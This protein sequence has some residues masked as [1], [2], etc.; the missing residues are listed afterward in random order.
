MLIRLVKI[1]LVASLGLFLLTVVFNNVTDYKSNSDFV[2]HVLAMDTTFPSNAPM[3]RVIDRGPV[4][5]AF[6]ASIILWEA[7]ACGLLFA[8][9]RKI[10]GGRLADAAAFSR[11]KGLAVAGIAPNLLQW[12]VAF[13]AVAG[14][15]FLV[16]QS[17]SWNGRE[18]APRMYMIAGIL[19][20][21]LKTRDEELPA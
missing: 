3:W 1:S 11:A 5:H 12:P 7:A 20:L 15:R 6:Y 4:Y 9:A 8:G 10:W 21:F 16:R 13:I 2:H 18:A 17:K 19:L 14:E